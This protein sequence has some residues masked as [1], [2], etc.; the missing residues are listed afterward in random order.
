MSSLRAKLGEAEGLVH[1]DTKHEEQHEP[2]GQ[3]IANHRQT[4]CGC[5]EELVQLVVSRDQEKRD[6]DEEELVQ[7]E[8]DLRAVKCDVEDGRDECTGDGKNRV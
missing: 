4:S 6:C 1:C 5:L 2:C 8:D 7:L 3:K